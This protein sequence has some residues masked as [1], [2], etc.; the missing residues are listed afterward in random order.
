VKGLGLENVLHKSRTNNDGRRE[1]RES[2]KEREQEKTKEPTKNKTEVVMVKREEAEVTGVDG[3]E[4]QRGRTAEEWPG[5]ESHLRVKG[6][7]KRRDDA[8]GKRESRE[9]DGREEEGREEG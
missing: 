1:P 4:S 2:S 5:G 6:G 9:G 3:P 7:E 8:R